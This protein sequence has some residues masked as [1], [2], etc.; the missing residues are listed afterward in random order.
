[1]SE[2]D[3]ELI[4]NNIRKEIKKKKLENERLL[5]FIAT[6]LSKSDIQ[7]KNDVLDIIIDDIDTKY[8][9]KQEVKTILQSKLEEVTKSKISP[10]DLLLEQINYQSSKNTPYSA[11]G[12]DPRP[13]VNLRQL[14][15]RLEKNKDLTNL[16][17]GVLHFGKRHMSIAK[18]IFFLQVTQNYL[19]AIKYM[20]I[21]DLV[22]RQ[23]LFNFATEDGIKNMINLINDLKRQTEISIV[24]LKN[25][26]NESQHWILSDEDKIRKLEAKLTDDE[27]KIR[28]L[29]AKLIDDESLFASKL[30]NNKSMINDKEHRLEIKINENYNKL[31]ELIISRDLKTT[32][33]FLEKI[34]NI[35][36]MIRQIK[37]E[38]KKKSE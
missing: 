36:D 18:R 28:K 3:V 16:M 23:T 10:D 7:N 22:N 11:G 27:D 20:T 30:E 34:S 13:Y 37:E 21:N 6:E 19:S 2:I 8:S 17:D 1:M 15:N 33:F 38:K 29:E 26:Q 32:E 5:T 14:I 35:E 24:E 31:K 9:T 12:S 25:Y 4:T